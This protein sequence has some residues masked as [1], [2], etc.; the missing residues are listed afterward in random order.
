MVMSSLPESGRTATSTPGAKTLTGQVK[1]PVQ[2][3]VTFWPR[4][5]PAGY[6]EVSVGAAACSDE[7]VRTNAQTYR[8]SVRGGMNKRLSARREGP[9]L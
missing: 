5:P 2:V 6:S 7:A 9:T 3:T 1:A 8:Q 4:W